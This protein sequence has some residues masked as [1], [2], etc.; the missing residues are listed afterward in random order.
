MSLQQAQIRADP[1]LIWLGAYYLPATVITI[2]IKY[3]KKKK[4]KTAPDNNPKEAALRQQW[5]RDLQGSGQTLARLRRGG[6]GSSGMLQPALHVSVPLG[7]SVWGAKVAE[8]EALL[9]L[10]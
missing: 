2:N 1:L 5:W 9:A 7:H 10:S 3:E 4:K 8:P 6:L